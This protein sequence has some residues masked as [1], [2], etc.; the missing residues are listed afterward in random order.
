M[1]ALLA[2]ITWHENGRQPYP[3]ALLDRAMDMAGLEVDAARPR[4]APALATA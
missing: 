1:G 4:S 3:A 2:A